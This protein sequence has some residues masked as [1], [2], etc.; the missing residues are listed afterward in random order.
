M[1]NSLNLCQ[2]LHIF[3]KTIVG[4]LLIRYNIEIVDYFEESM[5]T[6]ERF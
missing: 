4:E 2:R 1:K 3:H 5:T 6:I